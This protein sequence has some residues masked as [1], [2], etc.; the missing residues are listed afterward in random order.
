MSASS[1]KILIVDDDEGDRKQ[2]L[3]ALKKSGLSVEIV[4]V[5]GMDEAMVV[6]RQQV[7][8]C[9]IVDYH[10][11]GQDGLS[12]VSA[13]HEQFPYMATIMVT[14]QGDEVIASEV[15]KRGA[16][17]YIP[18]DQANAAYLKRTIEYA[19][20]K[21]KFQKKLD[22]QREELQSFSRVLA[23]DLK[24]PTR[25][26][27]DMIGLI[28]EKMAGQS[29]DEE[30]VLY[31][32]YVCK[33]AYTMDALVDSLITYTKFDAEVT[34]KEVSLAEC[35]ASAMAL[36]A[37]DIQRKNAKIIVQDLP[38]IYGHE[39]QLIQLFQNLI[40]NALKYNE[41]DCPT[42]T[43]SAEQEDCSMRIILHDN[44]IGIPEKHLK[45]IFEPFKRLHGKDSQY[46]GSGLGLATCQKIV[47]RHG[48]TIICQSITGQGSTFI[49]TFPS[50]LAA[51]V[52]I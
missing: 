21:S 50:F 9:A 26:I 12:G 10:M 22:Q 48:G 7:F 18:K 38:S 14:G 39:P 45:K 43:I 49:L 27:R 8:D 20:E 28:Q 15:I 13:F 6:C 41:S 36:L 47:E 32:S 1:L 37:G 40:G 33:A 19:L 4:E 30:V 17:D 3:R 16:G 2:V 5:T 42:I 35:L 29:L 23:H 34:F 46:A 44:G 31:M 11:P 52:K 25:H 24:S 51:P